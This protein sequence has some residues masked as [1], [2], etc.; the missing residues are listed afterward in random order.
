MAKDVYNGREPCLQSVE[1]VPD[2]IFARGD[3][4]ARKDLCTEELVLI[5]VDCQV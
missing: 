3:D 2:A 5:H 4:R 1:S